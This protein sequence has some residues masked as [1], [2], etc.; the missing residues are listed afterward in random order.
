MNP[1]D[2]NALWARH[3]AEWRDAAQIA[4][5]WREAANIDPQ[6]LRHKT[7]GEWWEVLARLDITLLVT[8]EYEHLV[9]AMS[10]TADGPL[11]TCMPL[12]HPSGLAVDRARHIVY[13]ASTRN[14]NQ[15]YDLEPVSATLPRLDVRACLLYTSPSPRDS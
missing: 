6:L 2:L 1:N 7:R 4:S 12:P 14:P 8:R 5:Q 11:V 13:V 3:T 9:M 15:V 10:V